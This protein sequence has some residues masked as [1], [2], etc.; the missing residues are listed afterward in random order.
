MSLEFALSTLTTSP[1]LNVLAV[2]VAI[3]SVTVAFSMN[4]LLT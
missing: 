1:A 2:K 4:V 3:L